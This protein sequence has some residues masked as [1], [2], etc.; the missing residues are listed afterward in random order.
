MKN[1]SRTL[2][3]F[4]IAL[5]WGSLTTLGFFVVPML[6]THL[7]TAQA[8]GRMAARLF[9][10]QTYVSLACAALLVALYARHPR[11]VVGSYSRWAL[12][13]IVLGAGL[14]MA[15]QWLVAPHIVARENLKL[16]HGLG[17][18]MYLVQWGCAT[19]LLYLRAR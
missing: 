12:V 14:S 4:A 15:V 16:W 9:D 3:L 13:W 2:S 8:A 18:A 6:F 10:V 17:S 7:D 19:A 1:A 5:W 11:D